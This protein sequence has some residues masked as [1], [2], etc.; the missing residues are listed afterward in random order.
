MA[1][2]TVDSRADYFLASDEEMNRL[3]N[4]HSVIKDAMGGRLLLL[5]VDHSAGALRILDSGT[6]D[7]TWIRDLQND[8]PPETKFVGTDIDGSKFPEASPT[9][10]YH[11]QDIRGPW[12]TEWNETFD[13][14]HQRLTLVAAGPAAKDV[15][16][17]LAAL[18][19]PGGWIQFMEADN[20]L[21]DKA[22]PG[23]RDFVQ[24]MKDIF[25]VMG[26]S[27]KL[28]HEIAPML[29]E[30]NFVNI[31]EQVVM[32]Q[33]GASNPNHELARQGAYSTTVAM[34]GLIQFGSTLPPSSL[35][36]QPGR[37][38][39]LEADFKKELTEHGGGYPLRVVWGQ[40]AEH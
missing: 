5:P 15:V 4:Q 31:H 33:L 1:S 8:M 38:E 19:K 23:F 25:S 28:T 3:S 13:I 40:K 27:L 35:S 21:D 14:V 29:R 39:T 24:L 34:Q 20:V 2:D 6:A 11:I 7:G 30:E 12:P 37:L 36:L 18:V 22:G 26:A 10:T 16:H 9:T 17:S 32:M